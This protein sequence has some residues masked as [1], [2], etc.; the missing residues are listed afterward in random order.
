M[1]WLKVDR[2]RNSV[3]VDPISKNNVHCE[4]KV[5]F[6]FLSACAYQQQQQLVIIMILIMII[7]RVKKWLAIQYNK[8]S[9]MMMMMMMHF[10][11]FGW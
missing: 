9:S 6:A 4:L 1:I 5:L 8:D 2:L 10:S 11:I 3:E 7:I